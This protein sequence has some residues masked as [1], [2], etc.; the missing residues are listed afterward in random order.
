MND[1]IAKGG[2][3]PYPYIPGQHAGSTGLG[4]VNTGYPL[5]SATTNV[6]FSTTT[7]TSSVTG[8]VSGTTNIGSAAPGGVSVIGIP[9][10]GLVGSG[11]LAGLG[12]AGALSGISAGA[13]SGIGGRGISGVAGFS[14]GSGSTVIPVSTVNNY[15]GSSSSFTGSS[16]SSGNIRGG[17]GSIGSGIGS[18]IGGKGN[19]CQ[20]GCKWF[21]QT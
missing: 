8:G 21:I 15:I 2:D 5:T 16:S 19:S 17:L 11:N 13:V 20:T 12:G 14:T 3:T 6:G 9:V 18:G 10:G 1:A 7:Y 4:A